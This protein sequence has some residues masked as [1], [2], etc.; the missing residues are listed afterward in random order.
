MGFRAYWTGVVFGLCTWLR[1]LLPPKMELN[2]HFFFL[3]RNARLSNLPEIQTSVRAIFHFGMNHIHRMCFTKDYSITLD[4]I[5][6]A[7]IYNFLPSEK[8]SKA[9][10]YKI[11]MI[12]RNF[13]KE[14]IWVLIYCAPKFRTVYLVKL[15]VLGLQWEPKILVLA[16]SVL[17]LHGF[18]YL[19][20]HQ[21]LGSTLLSST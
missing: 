12:K 14:T 4:T 19:L 7:K 9:F 21:Q 13:Q 20:T 3:G 6:R 18:I 8:F 2:L 11:E 5:L 10:L 1:L 16:P 15:P 17:V